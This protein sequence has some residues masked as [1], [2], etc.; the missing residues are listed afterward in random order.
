MKEKVQA[1]IFDMDGVHCRKA[2]HS[3]YCGNLHAG[4]GQ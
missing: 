4:P 2:Q 1:V 3:G